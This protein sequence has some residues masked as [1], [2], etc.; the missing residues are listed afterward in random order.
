M[1]R[2]ASS[3]IAGWMAAVLMVAAPLSASAESIAVVDLQGAVMQT[4]DGLG[5]Q[6]TLKKLFDRRQKELDGRQSDLAKQ[7][8]DIERQARI[9]SRE[10]LERRMEMWQRDMVQLQT[11]FLD[12]RKEIEK[13]QSEL[14]AP[15]I[16]RIVGIVARLASQN[17]YE[18]VLDKPAVAYARPDLD[19]TDRV[20]QMYNSGES[21]DDKK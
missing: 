21:G 8:D 5:A 1:R 12:Y 20:I 13:K 17:G 14:T 6:A 2:A 18:V 10:A 9:L 4:E 11:V 16:Q 7:R 3:L 19:I 15:I